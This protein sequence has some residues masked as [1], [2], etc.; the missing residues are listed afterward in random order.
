MITNGIE[1]IEQLISHFETD[2][3][4]IEKIEGQIWEESPFPDFDIYAMVLSPYAPQFNLEFNKEMQETFYFDLILIVKNFDPYKS[5]FGK[6]EPEKGIIQMIYDVFFSFLDFLVANKDSI[7]V[8]FEETDEKMSI[9]NKKELEG[10]YF[11][12]TIPVKV[13]FNEFEIGG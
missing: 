7:D 10:F 4:Y 5:I 9:K 12:A 3:D 2:L 1:L 11:V 8:T 13:K 6:Q